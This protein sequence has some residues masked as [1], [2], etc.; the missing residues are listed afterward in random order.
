MNTAIPFFSSAWHLP[1]VLL[2][3]FCLELLRTCIFLGSFCDKRLEELL[4]I[5]TGSQR[6]DFH[7]KLLK[8]ERGNIHVCHHVALRL[9]QVR[10][11]I[12]EWRWRYFA[13]LFPIFVLW[14]PDKHLNEIVLT[15]LGHSKGDVA[16]GNGLRAPILC[17]WG[18]GEWSMTL[19]M[20]FHSN[21]L[22]QNFRRIRFFCFCRLGGRFRSEN[23]CL[24]V[25]RS[26]RPLHSFFHP[27]STF[28]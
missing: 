19:S 16:T 14:C 18:A 4:A 17:P 24:Q 22:V 23:L 25:V 21:Y 11:T 28:A 27:C 3:I 7:Q 15:S 6:W 10:Q 5:N 12:W 13:V 8:T 1:W 26:H 20:S 2:L 9:L